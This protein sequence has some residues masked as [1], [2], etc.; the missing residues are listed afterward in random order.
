MI[1]ADLDGESLD[2][3]RNAALPSDLGGC[4]SS[5]GLTRRIR[6]TEKMAT[7][8]HELYSDELLENQRV[9]GIGV[10]WAQKS[11]IWSQ[12]SG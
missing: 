12:R 1:P 4:W 2:S 3:D 7:T 8:I 10:W 9:G 5:K 11:V 6:A